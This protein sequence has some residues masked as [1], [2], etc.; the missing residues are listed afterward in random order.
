MYLAKTPNIVKPLAQD[1]VWDVKTTKQEIFLTFDDGP[2]PEVTRQVMDILDGYNAKGT[3][4][5]VGNNV[6]L[7]PEVVAELIA[8]GHAI[9]NHTY[10]HV[11]GWETGNYSY[12]KSALNC[13][14]IVNSPLFRPPYGK[15]TKWQAQCLKKRFKL[16]M[17]DV[18]SGDFD[19]NIT[20]QKCVSNVVN[21]ATAG[22]II[23]FHDSQKSK[24]KMLY[25]L[26]RVLA[27]FSER[28]YTFPPLTPE[29]I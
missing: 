3:F 27:H 23:V 26:P 16:V 24:E 6:E 5:C 11:K 19:P 13:H 1:M 14:S 12:I 25:A 22:S 15:I 28:G 4:F 7:Y 29:R 20:Q 17:W 8:K 2:D 10:D 21:N 18:L 9:G